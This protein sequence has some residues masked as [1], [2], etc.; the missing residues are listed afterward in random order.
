MAVYVHGGVAVQL[1]CGVKENKPILFSVLIIVVVYFMLLIK[2]N[3]LNEIVVVGGLWW[4]F[5]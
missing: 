1:W 5:M 3:D 4:K 2:L